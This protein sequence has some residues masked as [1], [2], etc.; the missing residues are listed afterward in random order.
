MIR[1]KLLIRLA[2]IGL[3]LITLSIYSPPF[4]WGFVG[5]DYVQFDYIKEVIGNPW[6]GFSLFN[7]YYLSWYYRPL[8]LVW[9]SLLEAIF[10]FVPNGY[11][12]MAL[13]FH[14]LA[15]S[16]IYRVA[17]Q[18]K[19]SP[20]TAVLTATLFAIHSHWVDVITWISSI[21]I[22]MAAVFSLMALSAWLVYLKRPSTRQLLLTLL[23]CLLT[24]LSHEEGILLPPF[25]LLLLFAERVEIRDWRVNGRAIFL[26]LK[27][28]VSKQEALFFAILGIITL[29][30]LYVQLT[31]PNLTIDITSRQSTEWLTFLSWSNLAEFTLVTV[32]RFTFIV[33]FLGLTGWAASLFVLAAF[34]LFGLWFYWGGRAVRL[35]LLWLLLHLTFIFWALWTQLPELYAGRHIYQA[36]IGLVLAVGAS[37]DQLLMQVLPQRTRRAQRKITQRPLRWVQTGLLLLVTAVSLYHISQTKLAQRQWLNDLLEEATVRE[38]LATLYPT[39]SPESHFFSVRFPIMPQFTRSV[40][41][42]WYDTPLE[43]PSGSL[44]HL[45]QVK[46]ATP[47]FIVLDYVDGQV[48]NLMPE[49]QQYEE[50]I[51]LWAQPSRQVLLDENGVVT[52]VST[53]DNTLPI[54]E[55]ANGN[56]LA[57]KM[58]SEN[59]RWLSRSITAVIPTNSQL[60]TAIL[61]RPGLRYR[62]R[63]TDSNGRE[64]ILLDTGS[65]PVSSEGEGAQSWQ[66]VAI[67]LADYADST[68]VL[69]FELWADGDAENISGY[70]GN[71]RLV[72]DPPQPQRSCANCFKNTI[73]NLVE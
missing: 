42:L 31:R 44:Q 38:Q 56:Q 50:T 71:P 8:Q 53:P 36:M 19:I 7:P 34:T 67:P 2:M 12:W 43:R 25:L 47:D 1:N 5:D 35:G 66:R 37:A 65:T 13:L 73:P 69:R 3:I 27:S 62:L 48:Y 72:I 22:V 17:R 21:A 58:T 45:R 6:V 10:H 30:Y 23:F 64:Q 32:F 49:L 26:N 16:L 52:A 39:I 55:A 4:A 63:L 28:Q 57:L 9:F 61:P 68:V 46:R 14:A 18:L 15:V 59:S 54:V 33:H 20:F 40:I 60:H 51:F 29:A 11:Y 70:W 24:F 41:Q